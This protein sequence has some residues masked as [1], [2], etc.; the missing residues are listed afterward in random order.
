[1][2]DPYQSQL[3]AAKTKTI[4]ESVP[5]LIRVLDSDDEDDIDDDVSL[6]I[7]RERAL[8]SAS[9]RNSK[10][11]LMPG[12]T[13]NRGRDRRL[14][15]NSPYESMIRKADRGK[16]KTAISTGQSQS[17]KPSR[18]VRTRTISV[19]VCPD[20]FDRISPTEM[21]ISNSD[22]EQRGVFIFS[23]R[24]PRTFHTRTCI[25]KTIKAITLCQNQV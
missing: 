16:W 22:N 2:E 7:L 25:L 3:K 17:T 12:R 6:D 24:A 9:R 19:Q 4:N 1:M 5:T 8:E 10:P 18:K 15:T 13:Q 21:D 23:I 14:K 20:D 11:N